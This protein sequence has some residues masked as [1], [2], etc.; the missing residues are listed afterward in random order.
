MLIGRLAV[1]EQLDA[2][3]ATLSRNEQLLEVLV[4]ATTLELPG[5]YLTAG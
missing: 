5:W 3:R 2:L 4:R 1:G